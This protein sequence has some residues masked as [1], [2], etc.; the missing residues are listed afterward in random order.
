MTFCE[1]KIFCLFNDESTNNKKA[2]VYKLNLFKLSSKRESHKYNRVIFF[3]HPKKLL[4]FFMV[5]SKAADD[6]ISM[7]LIYFIFERE[8]KKIFQFVKVY[9]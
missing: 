7:P 6:D 5:D 2:R 4:I 8:K 9:L 3:T 1:S